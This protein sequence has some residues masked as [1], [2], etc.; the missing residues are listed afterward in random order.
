VKQATLRKNG[1]VL[2]TRVGM[3]VRFHQR[4]VGLLGRSG[5]PTDMAL[6]LCPASSIHTCFMRFRLDVAFLDREH[7]VLKVVRNL[8]PWRATAARG[9]HAVLEWQS[10]WLPGDALQPGDQ[11]DLTASASRFLWATAASAPE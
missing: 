2:I 3:A 10:G 7:R 1:R 4:L 5:L 8:Q 11:L 6:Y 9:S